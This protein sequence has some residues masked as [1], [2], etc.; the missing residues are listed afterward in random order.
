M[1]W[2]IFDLCVHKLNADG[3]QG[4]LV[5]CHTSKVKAKAHMAALYANEEKMKQKTNKKVVEIEPL[6]DEAI[7]NGMVEAPDEEIESESKPVETPEE[8]KAEEVEEKPVEEKPD[9]E[10]SFVSK[11]KE[12][13]PFFDKI[14]EMF[15]PKASKDIPSSLTVFKDIKGQYHAVGMVTNK[16]RD[17]DWNANPKNGG[18]IITEN[19]HK[20][21][22]S[23]LDAHPSEAPHLVA[24]HEKKSAT[25]APAE[26]WDY[27][28]G[29]VI[30]SWPL[31]E[32]EAEGIMKAEKSFGPLGMSH[33]FLPK[34]KDKA[35]GL[36]HQY[37]M[38]EA[39]H[40]PLKRAANL[41]TDIAVA[42]ME[43]KDMGK[44]S[45]EKRKYFVEIYGEGVTA[46]LEMDSEERAKAL[47][48][49]GVQSK[50]YEAENPV[51]KALEVIA[52]GLS[53]IKAGQ[54]KS[55]EEA[56]ANQSKV[57][58]AVKS[59]V[60]RLEKLEKSDDEKISK[61]IRPKLFDVMGT[62]AGDQGEVITEEE[63]KEKAPKMPTDDWFASAHNL[64]K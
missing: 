55:E 34:Q 2:K 29:F 54:V 22:M 62:K 4:D 10:K 23:Y 64:K 9:E 57:D 59:L 41:F 40:L 33:E 47:A 46:N 43:V 52:E 44:F 48:E 49:K 38:T 31:E 53:T 17:R 7:V 45:D 36:V 6:P 20:E 16:W 35:N 30:M 24:W 60:G 14:K 21:Y 5:K 63:A 51:N 8:P 12:Y 61:A 27:L 39:T 37:R 3:S 11:L 42:R 56:K 28:N 26:F 13:L 18:E 15:T 32:K 25:K 50:D 1:P 58:E 19:A